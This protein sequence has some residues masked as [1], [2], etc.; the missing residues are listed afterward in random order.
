[1]GWVVITTYGSGYWCECECG[2][3]CGFILKGRGGREEG[4]IGIDLSVYG[5]VVRREGG[6]ME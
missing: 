5:M 1:M 6:G 4:E 3:G 2:C